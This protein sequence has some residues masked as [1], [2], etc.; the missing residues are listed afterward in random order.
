MEWMQGV[1]CVSGRWKVARNSKGPNWEQNYR[2]IF[3]FEISD[4]Y[5]AKGPSTAR[6]RTL[7]LA[8]KQDNL[9]EILPML[10]MSLWLP[11]EQ[12]SPWGSFATFQ[13]LFCTPR[14]SIWICRSTMRFRGR[15]NPINNTQAQVYPIWANMVWRVSTTRPHC[16]DAS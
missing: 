13:L 16:T 4:I 10:L 9:F 6:C 5:F 15:I 2:G 8:S 7:R 11:E 1:E 3:F 14:K 12:V